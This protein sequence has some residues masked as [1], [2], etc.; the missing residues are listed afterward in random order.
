MQTPVPDLTPGLDVRIVAGKA[1]CT[2]EG[3]IPGNGVIGWIVHIGFVTIDLLLN[4]YRGER[5]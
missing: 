5:V 2:G 3:E 1:I 4:K